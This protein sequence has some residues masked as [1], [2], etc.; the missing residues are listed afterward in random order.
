MRRKQLQYCRL[1]FAISNL[2]YWDRIIRK[3]LEYWN[4]VL[5]KICSTKFCQSLPCFEQRNWPTLYLEHPVV[6]TTNYCIHPKENKVEKKR[7]FEREILLLVLTYQSDSLNRMNT[8]HVESVP[9]R[10]AVRTF[11]IFNRRCCFVTKSTSFL[12][13]YVNLKPCY[14]NAY[15]CYRYACVCGYVWSYCL[16][17]SW[18]QE[19]SKYKNIQ[20]TYTFA[21]SNLFYLNRCSSCR[22]NVSVI[23]P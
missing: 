10:R 7:S 11:S 16:T 23:N 9:S 15:L 14:V 5:F 19:Y 18:I 6:Y 22:T 12:D 2:P 17:W 3:L 1:V 21:H 20:R 13:Y 4:K 8:N